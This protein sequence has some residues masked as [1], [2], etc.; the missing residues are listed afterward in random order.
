MHISDWKS[1]V[2]SSDLEE[3]DVAGG[4][5]TVQ[6]GCVLQT[7]CEAVDAKGAFFPLD[8]GAR[9]SATIGGNISTNA[10]GNRV[11]RNGKIGRESCTESG[12]QSVYISVVAESLKPEK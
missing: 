8:L 12:G 4:T 11:I 1:D 9:G 7:V 5:A 3:I 6:A 2:C 10:G